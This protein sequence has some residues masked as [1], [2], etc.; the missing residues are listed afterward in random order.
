MRHDCSQGSQLFRGRGGQWQSNHRLSM[1]LSGNQPVLN[2]KQQEKAVARW[3][4]LKPLTHQAPT[5]C[6]RPGKKCHPA[7]WWYS[8]TRRIARAQV[9]AHNQGFCLRFH[10]KTDNLKIGVQRDRRCIHAV[11]HDV[12]LEH[13][14]AARLV[15]R[16]RDIGIPREFCGPG[17]QGDPA[18]GDQNGN[19]QAFHGFAPLGDLPIVV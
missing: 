16:V 6:E 17:A 15:E 18:E 7:P 3:F 10:G 5:C 8:Q 1:T 2:V 14:L 9:D 19:E 11:R 4:N 12:P 13:R